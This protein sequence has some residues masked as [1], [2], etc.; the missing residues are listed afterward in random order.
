[1][2]EWQE[3]AEAL[4]KI[5]T[6]RDTAARRQDQSASERASRLAAAT[7]AVS[8]V[9]KQRQRMEQRLAALDELTV[10][11]NGPREPITM[12]PVSSFDD[13]GRSIDQLRNWLVEATEGL[14]DAR[15]RER[16][17]RLL[18]RNRL[19]GAGLVLLPLVLVVVVVMGGPWWLG[20]VAIAAL[21]A[22]F[23]FIRRT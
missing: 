7:A 20:L 18:L 10:S 21:G 5:A 1:M 13:V 14:E 15:R 16:Q 19:I 2:S 22:S 3:Y 4:R 8:A 17:A 11:S 12:A 6:A 9:A 23:T